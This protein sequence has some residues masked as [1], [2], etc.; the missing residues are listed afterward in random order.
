MELV[1]D[2]VGHLFSSQLGIVVPSCGVGILE[3]DDGSALSAAPHGLGEDSRCLALTDV[4]RVEFAFE[5]ALNGACPYVLSCR[6][7][8]Y[9]LQARVALSRFVKGELR[10]LGRVELENGLPWT[11]LNLVECSL[12]TCRKGVQE[13]Y[14][15]YCW[16]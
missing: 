2:E 12:R 15:C 11:V 8:L 16:Q 4:E 9:V 13:E 3:V 10:L 1:D 14:G 6:L 7:H 5:V